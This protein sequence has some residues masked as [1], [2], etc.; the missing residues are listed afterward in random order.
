MVLFSIASKAE[1]NSKL[2]FSECKKLVY[3]LINLSKKI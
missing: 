1:Q 2:N 3:A